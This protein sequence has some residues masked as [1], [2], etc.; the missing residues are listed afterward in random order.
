MDTR[1][2]TNQIS[3]NSQS[4]QQFSI[5]IKKTIYKPE[6]FI[7]NDD[8]TE[9]ITLTNHRTEIRLEA[10]DNFLFIRRNE[11]YANIV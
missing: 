7:A 1:A 5:Y 2:G 11:A 10:F 3:N 8:H 4:H 6:V 9:R